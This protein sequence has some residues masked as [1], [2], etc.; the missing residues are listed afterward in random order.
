MAEFPA[1]PL[2]TDAYL[3]DTVHLSTTEH[4]A[5][6]LL[7]M[8]MWR[9]S[10]KKLRNDDAI[11]ARYARLTSTQW[12]R[13]K[14][15]MMEFFH[16]EDGWISQRRLTDE[17]NAVR[18]FREKQAAAGRASA[19]KRKGRHSTTVEPEVNQ[20][21]PPIPYSFPTP[22]VLEPKGSCASDDAPTLKPEHVVE[23][24]NDRFGS[25]KPKV[26]DLTGSRRQAIKARITQYSLD[27]FL[28]V[29]EKIERSQFLR[30]GSFCTFDWVMKAANFQKIIEG[31]YDKSTSSP[32]R[33]FVPI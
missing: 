18:Q 22:V 15:V 12:K 29:F 20:N 28:L 25:M 11:L 6:L 7:L 3:G 19:L 23:T 17:A 10:D 26:R 24:W 21:E 16:Q 8:T 9:S 2:W 32:K 1:F 31:N 13:M 27:D 30:D 5:Y 33:S 4:G 14:P